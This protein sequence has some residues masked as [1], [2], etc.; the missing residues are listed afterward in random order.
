MSGLTIEELV[1]ALAEIAA[2]RGMGAQMRTNV[3]GILPLD[4][5]HNQLDLSLGKSDAL[6][7]AEDALDEK[8]DEIEKLEQRVRDLESQVEG[9]KESEA[10]TKL[11]YIRDIVS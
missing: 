10:E 9:R 3:E 11:R 4:G 5:W 8:V 2:T 6:K 7:E 1:S